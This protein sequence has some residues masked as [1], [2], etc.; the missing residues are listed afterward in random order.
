LIDDYCG[1]A[2]N[3]TAKN[4][5]LSAEEITNLRLLN[6][7]WDAWISEAAQ[8]ENITNLTTLQLESWISNY[9]EYHNVVAAEVLKNESAGLSVIGGNL[10]FDAAIPS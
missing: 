4:F 5:S 8:I 1:G 2:S 6:V 10:S 7:S 3:E 9:V